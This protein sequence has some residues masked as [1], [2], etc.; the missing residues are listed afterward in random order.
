MAKAPTPAPE[1]AA[2]A[3]AAPAKKSNKL[4]FIII[5]V[6]VLAAG[7]GGAY[8][9]LGRGDAA[10][11]GQAAEEPKEPLALVRLDPFVVNLADEGSNR[12]LRLTVGLMVHGEEKAKHFEED[13][14]GRMKVRSAV[15]ELLSQQT[16]EHLVTTDGKSE[17]KKAIAEMASHQADH[18]EVSD[19]LFSEFIV[20]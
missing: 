19:V 13:S 6:L 16:A 17:L 11:A 3:E 12:F 5:G 9:M 20:Q 14:L 4:I 15:L 8:W 1:V 10:A 7:G 18:L 2:G